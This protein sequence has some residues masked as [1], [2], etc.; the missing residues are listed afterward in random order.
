MIGS[1]DPL[2]TIQDALELLG[3]DEVIISM[4]PVRLSR[5]LRHD[6]PAN[7]RALGVAVTEVIASE[8]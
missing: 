8:P 2:P 4:V 7:V 3:F 6:L 5:W 1:Q